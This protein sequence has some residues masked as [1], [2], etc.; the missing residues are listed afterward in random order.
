MNHISPSSLY[1]F[2]NTPKR[3]IAKLQGY[4]EEE[5]DIFTLGKAFDQYVLEKKIGE[6]YASLTKTM[7]KRVMEMAELLSMNPFFRLGDG[8]AQK[9]LKCKFK[10]FELL[11]Y[12]D[13]YGDFNGEKAIIDIKTTGNMSNWDRFEFRQ[14]QLQK[15]FYP[16]IC[17]ILEIPYDSFYYVVVS[18]GINP[19]V[20]I[21]RYKPTQDGKA[22]VIKKSQECIDYI[23]SE[24]W[25]EVKFPDL[26]FASIWQY[27]D[28]AEPQ[29]I[30][31]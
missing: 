13:F 25:K 14:A 2:I 15:D 28:M 27:L 1:N 17:D 18:T 24:E 22:F 31:M 29:V 7:Q 23:R 12:A 20:R 5:K 16:L 10:D 11:G 9:K 3:F 26:K 30:E 4:K 6:D 19:D 8:E 21:L